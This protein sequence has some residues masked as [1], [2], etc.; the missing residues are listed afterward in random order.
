MLAANPAVFA[1]VAALFGLAIGS[2]LNVV[3]HRLPL[4]LER[5]WRAQ[6]AEITN[7]PAAPEGEPISL[8]RP[9]SRFPSCGAQ[10]RA[11]HNIP[12]LSYLALHGRC[13]S[14][15]A[16]ISLRYPLVELATAIVSG[17][18]AWHFGFGW[19]AAFALIFSWYLIAM[20]GID[21]DR[22]LLPDVLTLP[23][24]WIG[25]LAS[26]WPA[27]GFASPRDALIGAAAGYLILWAVFHLF[28]L[29]TGKEGMGYGDFKLLAAIGA[30]L[31]WQLLPLV[32]LLAAV[33]GTAVGVTLIVMRRHGRNVPIPF[34]P[35]LA[36]AGWIAMLWGPLIVERYLGV[37]GLR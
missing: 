26:L 29:V 11:L 34:G 7:H 21:V 18:V 16:P 37:A 36:G 10:I 35:Y 31:G 22:Q 24:L 17:A 32:L 9:R 6:C 12:V 13:A 19:Q 23:L 2:F 25:L 30:W 8:V 4:M 14:C 5:Q 15:S 33:V 27:A 3:I 28:R 20:A 1:A